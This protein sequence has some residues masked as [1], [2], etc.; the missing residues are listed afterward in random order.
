MLRIALPKPHAKAPPSSSDCL[1]GEAEV[2]GVKCLCQVRQV[3]QF[4]FYRAASVRQGHVEPHQGQC[5]I[6]PHYCTLQLK[7]HMRSG[8]SMAEEWEGGHAKLQ[9]VFWQ[10]QTFQTFQQMSFQVWSLVLEMLNVF[11]LTQAV[12]SVLPACVLG[13][14][15]LHLLL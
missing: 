14:P 4:L 2:E 13:P 1:R 7:A 12:S 6:S 15:L 5:K 3:H 9:L 11:Y 8:P 10:L